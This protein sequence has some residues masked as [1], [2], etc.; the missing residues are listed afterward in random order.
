[1]QTY[2]FYTKKG[3]RLAIFNNF[4]EIIVFR[5]SKHDQFSRKVARRAFIDYISNER[6]LPLSFHPEVFKVDINMSGKEFYEWCS[7]MYYQKKRYVLP[8]SYDYLINKPKSININKH[9]IKISPF[10]KMSF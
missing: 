8:A 6:G 4:D 2:K 10:H 7:Q 1:M 5:C 9:L 3:E